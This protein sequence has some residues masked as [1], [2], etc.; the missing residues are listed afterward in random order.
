MR[1]KEEFCPCCGN[2]CSVDA[3]QCGRGKAHFGM[4]E[5]SRE[6]PKTTEDRIINLFRKCGHYLHHGASSGADPKSVLNGL[7]EEE[8]LALLALLTKCA[9]GI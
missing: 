9:E 2:N 5:G 7:T 4:T 3:L 8:K 6:E 1:E